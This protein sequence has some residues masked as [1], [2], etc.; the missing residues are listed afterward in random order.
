VANGIE[1]V[2][3][4]NDSPETDGTEDRSDEKANSQAFPEVASRKDIRRWMTPLWIL[5]GIA[6]ALAGI[7]AGISH[8]KFFALW[9]AYVGTMFGIAA[10]FVWFHALIAEHDGTQLDKSKPVPLSPTPANNDK[11]RFLN[12]MSKLAG[13]RLTYAKLIDLNESGL[14]PQTAG[15]W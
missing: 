9:T 8:Y 13:K 14:L 6:L 12:V 15:T 5:S 10:L 1:L 11:G 7:I 4:S 3:E 2:S